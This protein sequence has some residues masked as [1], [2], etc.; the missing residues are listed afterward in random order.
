MGTGRTYS[1]KKIEKT[2]VVVVRNPLQGQERRNRET[3]R[4][5]YTMDVNRRRNC[6]SYGGFGHLA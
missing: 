3:K 1:N 5:S 6:Y 2:N 4:D